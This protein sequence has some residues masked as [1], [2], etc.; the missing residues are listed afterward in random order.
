VRPF[1]SAR[2]C[3]YVIRIELASSQILAFRLIEVMIVSHLDLTERYVGGGKFSVQLS[4]PG[5]A[6]IRG[7][8]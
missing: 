3:P 2:T 6:I 5:Q 7:M 8:T 1:I 4:E